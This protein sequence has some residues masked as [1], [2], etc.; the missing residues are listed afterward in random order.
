MGDG[1]DALYDRALRMPGTDQCVVWGWG[2]EAPRR[3]LRRASPRLIDCRSF[4]KSAIGSVYLANEETAAVGYDEPLGDL[5]R[6]AGLPRLTSAS[7]R[8]LLNM[9][10][11]LRGVS[12]AA[13]RRV[14][15]DGADA[16]EQEAE[17]YVLDF[18]NRYNPPD[19]CTL[20][21]WCRAHGPSVAWTGTFDYQNVNYDALA[22]LAPF[23]LGRAL[24]LALPELGM[25]CAS[26]SQTRHGHTLGST[27]LQASARELCEFALHAWRLRD[28]LREHRVELDGGYTMGGTRFDGY[29][30]GWWS[31]GDRWCAVGSQGQRLVMDESGVF[32]RLHATGIQVG[33]Y[34]WLV[35]P[36]D[37]DA[38][39]AHWEEF[40]EMPLEA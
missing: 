35:R 11:G 18:A 33:E 21:D 38:W 32:C 15:V 8:S 22:H 23:V 34:D 31:L 2:D 37:D 17:D 25:E 30:C 26:F 1:H 28:Q 7:V 19:W 40:H 16:R 14:N 24:P 20:Y 13:A 36:K 27:G 39:S 9:T 3:E 4:T 29:S 12:F 5:A 10:A 6:S